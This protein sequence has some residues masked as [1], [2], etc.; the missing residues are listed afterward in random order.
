MTSAWVPVRAANGY[1]ERTR[2]INNLQESAMSISS[3]TSSYSN[4]IYDNVVAPVKNAAVKVGNE[5]SDTVDTAVDA[6]N[7]AAHTVAD[8]VSDGFKATGSIIDTSA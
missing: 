7:S 5:I 1:A 4:A 8:E 3:V 2:I 6:V